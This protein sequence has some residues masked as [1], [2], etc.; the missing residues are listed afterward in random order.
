MSLSSVRLEGKWNAICIARDTT[1]RKRAEEERESLIAEL[2]AKNAELER[3]TYTVS[4]D[5]R[6]PLI[7]IQGFLGFVEQAAIAGNVE[8]VQADIARI[9]NT[10]DKMQ[11]LL[12]E[13]LELSRIGRLVNP[14]QEVPFGDL[15]REAVS[16]VTGRLAQRGVEV[17]I[18]PDLL[19]ADGPTIYG[20][21]PR[22]REV[23]QNLVDNASKFMGDQPHPRVEIGM[24]RDGEERAFFVRDNGI[25]ID[26]RYHDKVFGLFDKL[27][28]EAEGSG[29]GLSIVKRIVEVH[30]GRIWVES[31]GTGRGSVF[32]FTLP[33]TGSRK[34]ARSET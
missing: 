12:D 26:P 34:A 18:A 28:Q 25:G 33:P 21:R 10:T 13:L 31:E 3:F 5:L 14:P 23:L 2:E 19:A 8:R 4:H 29:V 7:T 9:S 32:C 6:S 16:L 27:D 17:D 24:R 11:Q 20:D 1:K 22:L 30:G 15:A